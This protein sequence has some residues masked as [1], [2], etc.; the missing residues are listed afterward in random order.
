MFARLVA[1]AFLIAFAASSPTWGEEPNFSW[2]SIVGEQ[3]DALVHR[4]SEIANCSSEE[5]L[6]FR[7]KA[8]PVR[9][10]VQ[11]F[12]GW[13]DPAGGGLILDD[14]FYSEKIKT[15]TCELGK[16][17][18]IYAMTY[19]EKIFSLNIFYHNC[20][21]NEPNCNFRQTASD[22]KAYVALKGFLVVL[23]GAGTGDISA[24]EYGEFLK[25]D[26][27]LK[28]LSVSKPMG[29]PISDCFFP[30]LNEVAWR[31]LVG[32]NQLG[33]VI[34]QFSFAE[35]D[36]STFLHQE[37]DILFVNQSFTNS[38][39]E[40]EAKKV[41]IGEVN[42]EIDRITADNNAKQKNHLREKSVIES[43]E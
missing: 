1:Q 42:L 41:F 24:E 9:I 8:S 25:C 21:F 28:S 35:I 33:E 29:A 37:K 36:R 18:T 26:D 6:S 17:A 11:S 27:K 39:M 34:Q 14:V 16:A 23:P 19:Q 12:S 20:D 13:G 38:Q 22:Q 32:V 40:L 7:L 3:S 10:S 5:K 30:R 43:V 31:C 2:K 15:R 4:L